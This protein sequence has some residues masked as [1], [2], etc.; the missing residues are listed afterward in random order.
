MACIFLSFYCVTNIIWRKI[1]SMET[2]HILIDELKENIS[3]ETGR[4]M[5]KEL[6]HVNENIKKC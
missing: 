6:L 5:E 3:T 1:D 4:I 2:P